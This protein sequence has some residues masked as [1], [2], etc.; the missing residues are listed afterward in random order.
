M[1]AVGY[2][3]DAIMEEFGA[4]RVDVTVPRMLLYRRKRQAA[5]ASNR[6]C[7]ADAGSVR[8]CFN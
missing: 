3:L 6:T 4:A 1:K 7:N 5:G 2:T 8:A